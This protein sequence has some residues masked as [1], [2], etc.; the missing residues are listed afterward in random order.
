VS[1]CG[2]GPLSPLYSTLH[3]FILFIS[4]SV[5]WTDWDQYSSLQNTKGS[6]AV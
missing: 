2:H 1:D 5:D 3:R 4:S 6:I